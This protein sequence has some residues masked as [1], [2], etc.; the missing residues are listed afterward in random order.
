MSDKFPKCRNCGL[1]NSDGTLR[2]RC[3]P[4]RIEG[5]PRNR[6]E[7]SH[8]FPTPHPIDA[9]CEALR[10]LAKAADKDYAVL[11]VHASGRVSLAVRRYL[12]AA[13]SPVPTATQAHLTDSSL[14]LPSA[15]LTK[16]VRP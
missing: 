6:H 3:G 5:D 9:A 1:D 15:A 7:A 2:I 12:E 10:A 8:D 4:F 13:L 14:P 11:Q 16:L